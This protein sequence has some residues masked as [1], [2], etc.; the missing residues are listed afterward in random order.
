MV[1]QAQNQSMGLYSEQCKGGIVSIALETEKLQ[2]QIAI[3]Q[4]RV[5]KQTSF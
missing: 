2:D 5:T 3:H 1:S 4:S